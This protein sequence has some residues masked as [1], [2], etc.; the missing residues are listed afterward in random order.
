MHVVNNLRGRRDVGIGLGLESLDCDIMLGT[1]RRT[2]ITLRQ[3]L[4][5]RNRQKTYL[6][7]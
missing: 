5:D 3:T 2:R 4:L 6:T 1:H 7:A